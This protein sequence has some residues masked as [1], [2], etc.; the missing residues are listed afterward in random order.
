[1]PPRFY[2]QETIIAGSSVEAE[3]LRSTCPSSCCDVGAPLTASPGL[4]GFS[5]PCWVSRFRGH[6]Q[7]KLDIAAADIGP[8]MAQRQLTVYLHQLQSYSGRVAEDTTTRRAS[9]ERI[10]NN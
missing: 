10:R 6:F 7:V 4:A 9:E 8:R 3:S 2:R 5:G 1:M